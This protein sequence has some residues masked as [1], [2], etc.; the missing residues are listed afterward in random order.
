MASRAA[1]WAA[2]VLFALAAPA[3]ANSAQASET[4]PVKEVLMVCAG[5]HN[6]EP[7]TL[8]ASEAERIP[9]LGGQQPAYLRSALEA[10]RTRQRDHF[11]MRGMAAG[12]RGAEL[13][14]AIRYL[15]LAEPESGARAVKAPA[16]APQAAQRCVACHGSETQPPASAQTPRLAGQ[17]APYIEAAF[18]AYASGARRHDTMTPQARTAEGQPSL[19]AEELREVANWFSRQRGLVAR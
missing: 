8:A 2:L 16:P 14:A 10:Y 9:R 5:C 13:D 4:R 18:T 19:A 6:P 12:L 17:H 11:Y 1:S 3:G 15:S 7:G